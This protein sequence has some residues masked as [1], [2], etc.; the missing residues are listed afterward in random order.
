MTARTG[1]GQENRD[2]TL[3]QDNCSRK[4]STGQLGQDTVV[5]ILWDSWDML[6]WTW[7]STDEQGSQN[8]IGWTGKW[9]Q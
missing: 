1:L 8:M 6:A 5:N 9:G 3:G 2:R 4:A 7:V